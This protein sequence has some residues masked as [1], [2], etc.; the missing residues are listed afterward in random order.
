MGRQ[1]FSRQTIEGVLHLQ[2]DQVDIQRK[3]TVF[4]IWS[5]EFGMTY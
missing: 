4:C 3:E 2:E 5:E 1:D